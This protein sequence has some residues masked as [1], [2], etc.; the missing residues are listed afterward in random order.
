[1]IPTIEFNYTFVY[2]TF[3]PVDQQYS[4]FLS[5]DVY[6]F[7][8]AFIGN[9][10]KAV[11]IL[12]ID[13]KIDINFLSVQRNW[14]MRV[15]SLPATVTRPFNIRNQDA[16]AASVPSGIDVLIT[17]DPPLA[18]LDLLRLGCPYRCYRIQPGLNVFAHVHEGSGAGSG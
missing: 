8:D 4:K 18:H 5:C 11:N 1:M 13:D 16:W 6:G 3:R 15:L 14:S 2:T 17:H 10:H 7:G 9:L 12:I